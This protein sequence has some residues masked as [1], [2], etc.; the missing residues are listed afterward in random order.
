MLRGVAK[1]AHENLTKDLV[2]ELGAFPIHD[3]IDPHLTLKR[4]FELDKKGMEEVY[5]VL[6]LFMTS[7]TQSDYRLYGLNNFGDGVIYV[8]VDPSLEMSKTVKDLLIALRTVSGMT[9]EEVDAIEDDFHATLAMRSLKP[10]DFN[11]TM[12]YLKTKNQLD[13]EMKFDNIAILKKEGE[14][15]IPE[16]VWELGP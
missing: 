6:D 16:H 9:F 7:H 2:E 11:K 8:D 5:A 14:K 13:F 1:V 3:R 10:F 4:W 15:W 12:E